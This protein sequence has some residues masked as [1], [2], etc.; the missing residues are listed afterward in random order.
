MA[1]KKKGKSN[2][3]NDTP[4]TSTSKKLKPAIKIKVRHIL[5]EKLSKAEAALHRIIKASIV[6]SITPRDSD[7]TRLSGW[8]TL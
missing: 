3:K 6:L 5:C 8:R 4:S 2:T 1:K 7:L